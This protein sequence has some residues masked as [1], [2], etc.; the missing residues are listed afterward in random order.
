MNIRNCRLRAGMTQAELA[1]K[2]GTSGKSISIWENELFEPRISSL[3][4]IAQA[5]G[6]TVDH[7]LDTE[8]PLQYS[9][10]RLTELL[11][12]EGDANFC[13]ATGFTEMQVWRW[14][15][16]AEPTISTLRRL[17]KHFNVPVGWFFEKKE[18]E[19]K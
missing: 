12:E 6:V 10:R 17:A 3:I 4:L 8:P 15:N 2:A 7:L 13:D 5:L 14:R 16:G 9:S 11:D 1:E 18:R 19:T